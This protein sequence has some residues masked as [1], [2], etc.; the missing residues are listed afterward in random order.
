MSR[1]VVAAY[2]ACALIWGTT[3]YAIRLCIGPGG[4][5]T[6]D[7]L[8]LRFAIAI[9]ILIP[10]AVRCRPWPRGSQWT[11]LVIAGVLD[12]VG[13]L[14]VYLGEEHVPGA[15]AAVLYGT[16]PLILAVLLRI[17]GMEALT[18]RHVIGA[19]VSLAGVGVLFFDRLH[20]SAQQAAGVAMIIG[21]VVVATIYSMIMKR[22]AHAVHGAVSTTVFLVVTAVVLGIVALVVGG[23]PPLVWPPPLWPT[24][25]LLYLAVIGSVVAFLTYFWLLHKTSLL[26]TSTLVFVYPL[27]AIATDALFERE[28]LTGQAYVGAAITLAGLGVSLRRVARRAPDG[29]L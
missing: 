1:A 6:L 21:S 16:Q 23:G 3:W 26:V 29:Q 14:L 24:V 13:Y 4:F 5:A 12:A 20:V 10:I 2:L 18:R 15:V 17:T 28:T 7:A 22:H 8:A 9:V 27:V 19:L 25:A 11:Y